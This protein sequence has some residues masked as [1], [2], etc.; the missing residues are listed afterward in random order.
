MS[1]TS[2]MFHPSEIDE[3]NYFELVKLIKAMVEGLDLDV[4]IEAD[5]EGIKEFIVSK[6]LY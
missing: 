6:S 5:S 2:G 4:H 3:L 1:D